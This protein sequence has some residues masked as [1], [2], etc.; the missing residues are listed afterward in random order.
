M[1][2]LFAPAAC[3]AIAKISSVFIADIMRAKERHY[4]PENTRNPSVF[5]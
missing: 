5:G 1:S 4:P 2:G 3:K